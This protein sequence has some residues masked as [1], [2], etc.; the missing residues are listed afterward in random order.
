[1]RW[2]CCNLIIT[3]AVSLIHLF[4]LLLTVTVF[5][6]RMS[7]YISC[8]HASF[9]HQATKINGAKQSQ[10]SQLFVLFALHRTYNRHQFY[11]LPSYQFRCN[12]INISQLSNR[13]VQVTSMFVVNVM[14]N[15]IFSIFIQAN[16]A[17][18]HSRR[19]PN[20]N[21]MF[22]IP[23]QTSKYAN[24]KC[25]ESNNLENKNYISSEQIYIK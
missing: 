17:N 25:H 12:L 24:N 5:I 6:L 1:M 22:F 10:Y 13:R 20:N 14:S 9:G 15:K 23:L 16:I 19:L 8:L 7:D 2:N 11:V 4:L 3:M 18:T 21:M